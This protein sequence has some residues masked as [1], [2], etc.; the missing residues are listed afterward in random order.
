[1]SGTL[2]IVV[3]PAAVLMVL[4]VVPAPP[5]GSVLPVLSLLGLMAALLLGALVHGGGEILE[6]SDETDTEVTFGFVGFLDGFGDVLDRRCKAFEGSMDAL[7]ASRDALEEFGP[8]I[9][10]I[11]FLGSAHKRGFS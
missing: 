1:V 8:W 4:P 6:G 10:G 2:L 3:M 7:E 5:P 11:G 9:V